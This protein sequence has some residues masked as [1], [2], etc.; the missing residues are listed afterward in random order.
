MALLLVA[1]AMIAGRAK[2]DQN[3]ALSIARGV[4]AVLM[5]AASL[6]A[7]SGVAI[8]PW[9]IESLGLQLRST[10][11]LLN[12][13]T[14]ALA[15]GLVLILISPRVTNAY[16]TGS[17][18]GFYAVAA[19]LMWLF[20][21]GPAPTV[22]GRPFMRQGPYAL[23]MFLPGFDS[24]R[25]PARFA[26][27]TTLCLAVLGGILFDRLAA[28]V[29]RGRL[30]L[31]IVVAIGV[32][33]DGWMSEMRLEWP[34][35][36]WQAEQCAA[37]GQALME[38]PLGDPF[39]DAAA[40]YRAMFH[41]HPVVNG[42]SG[43]FP[44]PYGTLRRALSG[45]NDELLTQLPRHGVGT[46]IVDLT[47]S[48]GDQWKQY[49]S[50]HKLAEEVCSDSA[51]VAYRLHA[52]PHDPGTQAGSSLRVQSIH[53]NVHD[54]LTPLMQDGLLSTRWESGP[55]RNT[56]TM[57][58]DLGALRSINTIVLSLGP[59]IN[60]F[61][62]ELAI[63]ASEDGRAW[64]EVWRGAGARVLFT[65]PFQE[66]VDTHVTF[67]LNDTRARFL[68]LQLLSNE[69]IYYWSVAELAVWGR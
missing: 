7:L 63:D 4:L 34:P 50:S 2:A 40:M 32:M 69:A 68:R 35:A 1:G 38:L 41:G 3:K 31:A 24:L 44:G 54:A 47:A 62:R 56:T 60:D 27:V 20:S 26:M 67:T 15:L 25:V 33:A 37:P 10:G 51:H 48:S 52:D 11:D 66:P 42:Y 8:G 64:I 23:L 39:A 53:A 22:L 28:R 18:L 29:R 17:A 59:F 57:D 9:Q 21:L 49:V 14:K 12:P 6:I 13:L 30:G 43:Y 65:D 61:P 55:Q 46:V 36:R 19:F 58:I 45:H 16:R 5:V